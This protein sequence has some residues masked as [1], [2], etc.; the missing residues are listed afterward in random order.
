MEP[1][2]QLFDNR[3]LF[4]D[5]DRETLDP[6]RHAVFIISRVVRLGDDGGHP[7]ICPHNHVDATLMW[8]H[9][10]HASA[11][12]SSGAHFHNVD[13]GGKRRRDHGGFLCPLQKE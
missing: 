2:K 11:C 12:P 7:T 9:Y 1:A 3:S 5:V 8:P 6:E 13:P 10:T 4:G